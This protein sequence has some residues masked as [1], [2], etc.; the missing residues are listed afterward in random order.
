MI[1]NEHLFFFFSATSIDIFFFPTF[2]FM[3]FAA[4]TKSVCAELDY[5]TFVVANFAFSIM[6][7]LCLK[8]VLYE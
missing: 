4:I 6:F 1:V 2:L 3:Q 7:H 5:A 8:F